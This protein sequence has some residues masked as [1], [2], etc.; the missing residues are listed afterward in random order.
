MNTES[1]Y[2]RMLVERVLLDPMMLQNM[3]SDCLWNITETNKFQRIWLF[4][5]KAIFTF[6]MK[7]CCIHCKKLVGLFYMPSHLIDPW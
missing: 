6:S 4:F 1:K 3:I 7:Q 2:K 5:K